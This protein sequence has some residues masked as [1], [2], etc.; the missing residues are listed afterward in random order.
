MEKY[1][2]Y[3]LSDEVEIQILSLSEQSM[4]AKLWFNG[5]GFPSSHHHQSEETNVF[6]AGE[7]EALKGDERVIV[8]TGDMVF[9]ESDVE[10]NLTCLSGK[11]EV[12]TTWT[13][14]RQDFIDKFAH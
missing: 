11:G 5:K 1:Q 3:A 8:K 12:I 6:V 13:P 9:V 4:T 10:H 2:K 14:P 7:F